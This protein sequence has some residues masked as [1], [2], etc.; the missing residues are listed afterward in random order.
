[1]SWD[2]SKV[3]GTMIHSGAFSLTLKF[4]NKVDNQSW[5][6]TTVYGP[7]S[8]TIRCEFWEELCLAH[9]LCFSTWVLCGNFNT[10]FSLNDKNRGFP[11]S[12]DL[13]IAQ[14]F[15][16]E[17]DLVDPPLLGRRFTWTNGQL[18]PIWTRLERFLLSID[19]LNMH[20]NSIQSASPDL[21]LIIPPSA[22]SLAPTHRELVFFLLKKTG[23]LMTNYAFLF[24]I[25]GATTTLMVVGPSPCLE[26]S[27]ILNLILKLGHQRILVPSLLTKTLCFLKLTP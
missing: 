10:V 22:L 9:D 19:W 14:N 24:M 15:L 6:C 3:S 25:G 12:S 5:A 16:N 2:S 20:P 13:T 11:N 4:T 18:D 21:D 27:I 23:I 26:N 7:T 1:M 17:L 8:R